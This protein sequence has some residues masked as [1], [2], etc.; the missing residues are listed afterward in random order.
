MPL[1]SFL[2][3]LLLYPGIEQFLGVGIILTFQ[4]F[5]HLCFNRAAQ[6]KH[7]TGKT[8]KHTNF[9]LNI[10]TESTSTVHMQLLQLTLSERFAKNPAVELASS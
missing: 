9:A 6:F 8:L 10:H 7:T 3:P 4:R 2:L 1:H 5:S